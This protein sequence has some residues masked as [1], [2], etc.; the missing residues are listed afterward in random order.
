MYLRYYC[1]NLNISTIISYFNILVIRKEI[2][3]M[4]NKILKVT[5]E[6]RSN[7]LHLNNLTFVIVSRKSKDIISRFMVELEM[8]LKYF[9]FTFSLK[10]I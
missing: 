7:C 10:Y 1:L 6:N 8:K 9:A 5:L 3:E 2:I 4:S